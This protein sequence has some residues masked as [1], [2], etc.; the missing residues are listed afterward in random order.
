M[1]IAENNVGIMER[2]LRMIVGSGLGIMAMGSPA[3][4]SYLIAVVAII[5]F[6]TGALG[7]CPAYSVLG[8]NT[9]K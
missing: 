5:A 8:I 4:W 7:T 1:S 6:V 9:E 2:L 3:P